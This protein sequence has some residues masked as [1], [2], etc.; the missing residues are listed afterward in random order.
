MGGLI[1]PDDRWATLE[2]EWAKALADFGLRKMLMASCENRRGQFAKLERDERDRIIARFRQ[3]IEKLRARMLFSAVSR[4]LWQKVASGSIL[5]EVF[6]DPIDFCFNGRMRHA[7][8]SRRT[9]VPDREPVVVTF[10]SREENLA[11]W[12]RA[13]RND[14]LIAWSALPSAA[15]R[16][17]CH[18]RRAACAPVPVAISRRNFRR[19][20]VSNSRAD[21]PVESPSTRP[22]RRLVLELDDAAGRAQLLQGF[23]DAVGGGWAIGGRLQNAFGI[24][25]NRKTSVD[26]Q[27]GCS[28]ILIDCVEIADPP[29][30]EIVEPAHYGHRK[31]G[32]SW[33]G[34]RTRR[35]GDQR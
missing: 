2:G 12:R 29:D 19:A 14:G 7:L 6:A 16:R 27:V 13:T 26:R 21:A 34:D 9:T 22:L 30:L 3:I 32:I 23:T 1:A 5:G 15:W 24:H 31:F 17:F 10:D 4:P 20:S 11:L 33:L 35:Q 8:E 18:W 28:A 25:R